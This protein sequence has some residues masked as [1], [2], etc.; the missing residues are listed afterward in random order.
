MTDTAPLSGTPTD[1][2]WDPPLGPALLASGRCIEEEQV[3]DDLLADLASPAATARGRGPV[4]LSASA[5][6]GPG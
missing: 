3:L 2:P 6:G 5:A 4:G 1:A